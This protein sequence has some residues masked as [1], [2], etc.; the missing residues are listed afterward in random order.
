MFLW[1]LILCSCN[2]VP[3]GSRQCLCRFFTALS[4]IVPPRFSS[5]PEFVCLVYQVECYRQECCTGYPV[6]PSTRTAVL[7]KAG[8]II[9]AD[10]VPM[11]Q[12]RYRVSTVI[13]D[14]AGCGMISTDNNNAVRK[15]Q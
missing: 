14:C 10:T 5:C 3:S 12:Y 1:V 6:E 15:V 8:D 7:V 9:G 2:S 13:L 4:F 11:N